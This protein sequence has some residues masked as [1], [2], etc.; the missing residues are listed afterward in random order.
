MSTENK[1]YFSPRDHLLV[2]T[3][4]ANQ[5]E[6]RQMPVLTVENYCKWYELFVVNV[7]GSI[8]SID[9]GQLDDGEGTPYCDHAPNP[10]KVMYLAKRLGLHLDE[11]AFEMIIGRWEMEY[12]G[13]YQ[14]LDEE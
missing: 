9:F 11:Q 6:L 14:G 7:D 1:L 12:H 3:E 8:K 4:L 13:C 2:W 5:Q 10:V